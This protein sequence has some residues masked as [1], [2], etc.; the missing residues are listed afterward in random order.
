MAYT[1]NMIAPAAGLNVVSATGTS[2]TAD[3]EG[4]ITGVSG[5]DVNSLEA[6]GCKFAGNLT[7][8]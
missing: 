6:S 3:G 2:Y 5:A 7:Q 1:F 4:L 8:P